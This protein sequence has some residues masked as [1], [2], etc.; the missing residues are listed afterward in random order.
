[1]MSALL[2][3]SRALPSMQRY[4]IARGRR[5]L[6]DFYTRIFG[7][8]WLLISSRNPLSGRKN[9]PNTGEDL[10]SPALEKYSENGREVDALVTG[11]R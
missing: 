3:M 8:G 1:M 6:V 2:I 9:S 11:L 10:P 5:K 7:G 4:L